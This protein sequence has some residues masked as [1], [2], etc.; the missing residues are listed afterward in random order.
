VSKK[1][2]C[3]D[4]E[5]GL[6]L[7][8]KGL[9]IDAVLHRHPISYFDDVTVAV[10]LMVFERSPEA[11]GPIERMDLYNAFGDSEAIML[12]QQN[13][14][15]YARSVARLAVQMLLTKAEV[16][17]QGL[18]LDQMAKTIRVFFDHPDMLTAMAEAMKRTD[19]STER[20]RK[21]RQVVGSIFV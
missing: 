6:A 7:F 3:G 2:V 11:I 15:P 20:Y 21:V 14:A 9:P 17:D 4:A 16:L 1:D 13:R 12:E 18:T 19:A 5:R 8:R 10:W